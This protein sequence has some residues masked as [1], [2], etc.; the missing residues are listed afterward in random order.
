MIQNPRCDIFQN[1]F[2]A[3]FFADVIRKRLKNHYKNEKMIPKKL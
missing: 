2:D 3:Y 1:V